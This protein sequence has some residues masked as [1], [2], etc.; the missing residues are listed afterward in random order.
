MATSFNESCLPKKKKNGID[1][2][3]GAEQDRSFSRSNSISKSS[4]RK[5]SSHI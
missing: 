4:Q 2:H 5:K 1:V 3:L